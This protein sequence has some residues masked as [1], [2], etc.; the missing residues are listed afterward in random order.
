M[1]NGED[2]PTDG[3]SKAQLAEVRKTSVA[4]ADSTDTDH[5]TSPAFE[6]AIA[7]LGEALAGVRADLELRTGQG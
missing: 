3:V 6:A 2:D 5:R 7:T 1:T 4:A